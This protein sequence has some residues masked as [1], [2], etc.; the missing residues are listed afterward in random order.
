MIGIK[1]TTKI[2]DIKN[3]KKT[4]VFRVLEIKGLRY[5]LN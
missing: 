5:F 2:M 4:R 3:G 1:V